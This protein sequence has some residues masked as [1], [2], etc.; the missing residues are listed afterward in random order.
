LEFA[1]GNFYTGVDA[2]I[3]SHTADE[4]TLFVDGH[5]ATDAEF[6]T[7]L[8]EIFPEVSIAIS[9]KF[10]LNLLTTLAA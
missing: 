5:V 4:A 10:F 9:E 1:S 7:F 6:S 3:S 8:G 2:L